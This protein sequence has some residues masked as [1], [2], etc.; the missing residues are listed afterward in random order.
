MYFETFVAAENLKYLR[1]ALML[2][3]ENLIGVVAF[4]Q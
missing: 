2:S 3:L 4:W 1:S